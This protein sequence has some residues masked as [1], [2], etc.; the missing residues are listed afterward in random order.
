MNPQAS[1]PIKDIKPLWLIEDYSLLL[2]IG[3][4]AIAIVILFW[5]IWSLLRLWR[6]RNDEVL[7]RQ[8]LALSY[9]E[10]RD[11][12][13]FAYEST[14]LLNAIQ[15]RLQHRR[16]RSPKKEALLVSVNEQIEAFINALSIYKYT[17]HY[18]EYLHSEIGQQYKKIIGLPQCYPLNTPIF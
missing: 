12:K 4:L 6:G 5:V 16:F 3:V 8:F 14:Q 15:K 17:P 10:I 1:L 13:T 9:L 11:T 2:F 7:K 18:E